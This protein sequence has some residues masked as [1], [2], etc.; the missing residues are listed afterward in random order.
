MGGFYDPF[1]PK[2]SHIKASTLIPFP[3]AK[4]HRQGTI[5]FKPA[6]KVSQANF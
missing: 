5:P 3:G 6:Y 4:W 2:A 1:L